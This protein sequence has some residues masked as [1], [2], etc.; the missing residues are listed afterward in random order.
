MPSLRSEG[1]QS[2]AFRLSRVFATEPSPILVLAK[3]VN[4]DHLP[5][6]QIL[7]ELLRLVPIG[8]GF[9]G[10]VNAVQANLD[11]FLG[12]IQNGDG[13]AIGNVNDF[14]LVVGGDCCTSKPEQNYTTDD[15][16][17]CSHFS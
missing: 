8:L 14:G 7:G 1:H 9:F 11:L 2:D 5:C 17:R 4:G 12:V 6:H 15:R 13:V 16:F 3:S 10:T